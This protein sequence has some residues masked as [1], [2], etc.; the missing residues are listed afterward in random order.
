MTLTIRATL[1]FIVRDNKVLLLKKSE[2]L[3]GAGKW[4]APG[5]KLHDGEDPRSCAVREVFE[6]TR[7]R[8]KQLDHVGIVYFYK[9][10]RRENPDWTVHV[11]LSRDFAGDPVDRREGVT[12]WFDVDALPFEEMWEDDRYWHRM[13]FEGRKF[14]GRFYYTGN[15]EKLID[16]TLANYPA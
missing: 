15:F 16:F 1:C 10:D 4:N 7:L 14:E 6:E 9:F 13:V 2:G 5:G 3:F 8:V 12:R 11:F